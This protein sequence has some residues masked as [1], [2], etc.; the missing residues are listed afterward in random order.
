MPDISLDSISAARGL[1]LSM[2]KGRISAFDWK[3][4]KKL[5]NGAFGL[6]LKRRNNLFMPVARVGIRLDKGE[7]FGYKGR[8]PPFTWISE[9]AAIL[10]LLET[11][12]LQ[13]LTPT[14]IVA[15]FQGAIG[16]G[17]FEKDA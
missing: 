1:L 11:A 4:V 14:V 16:R 2:I 6:F 8:H 13:H 3:P 15:A 12:W 7:L 9:D 5:P 10:R 17:S